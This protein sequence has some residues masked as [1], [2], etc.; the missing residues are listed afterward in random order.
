MGVI[1]LK[2]VDGFTQQQLEQ[3][4]EEKNNNTGL[5]YYMLQDLCR[6]DVNKLCKDNVN[7]SY[8]PV[9]TNWKKYKGNLVMGNDEEGYK[10]V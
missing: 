8:A 3:F 6:K 1:M 5:T 9:Q 2:T 7:N 10:F 4:T